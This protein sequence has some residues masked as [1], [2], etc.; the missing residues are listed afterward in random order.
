MEEDDDDDDRNIII[1]IIMTNS[2]IAGKME[3]ILQYQQFYRP[4]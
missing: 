1:I 2:T 4:I 3:G